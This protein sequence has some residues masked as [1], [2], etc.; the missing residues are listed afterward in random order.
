MPGWTERS[1]KPTLFSPLIHLPPPSL[2]L[3]TSSPPHPPLSGC[4]PA[5]FTLFDLNVSSICQIR[6]KSKNWS[7][8]FLSVKPFVF[9]QQKKQ[10]KSTKIKTP[11]FKDLWL[12]TPLISSL[13]HRR[14]NHR[15]ARRQQ[16]N[17]WTKF[18]GYPG[19]IILFIDWI[20]NLKLVN[21]AHGCDAH[22]LVDNLTET[23]RNWDVPVIFLCQ[24]SSID[25]FWKRVHSGRIWEAEL[26]NKLN[27]SSLIFDYL[28]SSLNSE[29]HRTSKI[30]FSCCC[31][32]LSSF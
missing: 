10:N 32:W 5:H 6:L 20:M 24:R 25:L 19:F 21:T 7:I 1:R 27:I 29:L 26:C 14:A 31:K 8:L 2:P 16:L 15:E 3:L 4:Q 30:K 13:W 12:K 23:E 17:R 18:W 9:V 11:V 28:N 22:I